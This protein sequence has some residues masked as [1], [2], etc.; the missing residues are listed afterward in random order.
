MNDANI[1]LQLYTIRSLTGEDM[2][3][4]LRKIAAQ[5]YLAVEFAGYGGVPVSQLRALLDELGVQAIAAHTNLGELGGRSEELLNELSTLGCK[6]VVLAYVPEEQRKTAQQVR[7]IGE[8]LNHYGA[9]VRDA[10]MQFAY[11]NHAFE[12]E[13]LEGT[14][15]FDILLET[16]DPAL[17]S[18]EL[19]VYWVRRGGLD[20]VSMLERLAGRVPLVHVKDMEPGEEQRDAPA[21]EGIMPWGEILPA[22]RAAGAEWFVVEQDHPRDPLRDVEVSLNNLKKMLEG[23][24]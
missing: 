18:F 24:N 23:I 7:E 16:V 10:G 8:S 15:M 14:N 11:H 3:G 20:P 9:L 13:S 6:Y 4:T 21:G 22:A 2:L 12:F 17:V 19:D 1:A 5:G